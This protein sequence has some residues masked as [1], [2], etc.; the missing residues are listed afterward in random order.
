MP[1]KGKIPTQEEQ[2]LKAFIYGPPGMGKT[3]AGLQFPNAYI[4]DTAKETSRYWKLVQQTNSVV[5]NC[6]DPYEVLEELKLLKNEQHRFQTVIIDEASTLYTNL[7][8]IWT[9]KFVYAQSE[10]SSKHKQSENE[11]LLEDFG[12]RYWDKVKRDWKRI[13]DLLKQ[14]DMNVIINAHEKNKYGS[15]QNIIGVTSDSDKSDEY[16]FDFVFRLIKRGQEYKAITEKQR[17]LPLA[18]DPE[19]K[20][21]PKEFTW[22]YPNLLKFYHKE[23]LEK[24]TKNS[25]LSVEEKKESTN[26]IP[27]ETKKISDKKNKPDTPMDNKVKSEDEKVTT[28]EATGEITNNKSKK[29][30]EEKTSPNIGK[31]KELIKKEEISIKDFKTFLQNV[32]KW[33][34]V[35]ILT[36]LSDK[37]QNILLKNWE[38]KIIPEFKKTM[39]NVKKIEEQEDKQ[40]EKKE[41]EE[42]NKESE[43]N[44]EPEESIRPDQRK[45][46]ETLLKKEG[47]DAKRFLTGFTIKK[48]EEIS[49]EGADNMIKNF[50]VMIGAFQ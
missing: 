21:F 38:D 23:Y 48:W 40:E 17:I 39:K 16:F 28:F 41:S 2:R 50:K 32:C 36:K 8:R 44:Y 5:F 37:E 3:I 9:D 47:V 49:Q 24:S 43:I 31:I 12:Y 42:E 34:H 4:I 1:L 26:I 25:K 46:I 19:A 14:L 35:N 13:L 6:T 15:N 30:K 18:I 7:Q 22:D 10:R 45:K 33:K 20:R 11:N 27:E 29:S